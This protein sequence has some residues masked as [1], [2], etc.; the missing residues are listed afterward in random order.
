MKWSVNGKPTNLENKG[1]F[2]GDTLGQMNLKSQV[3]L[4]NSS[5]WF[6]R[7]SLLDQEKA[8]YKWEVYRRIDWENQFQYCQML[9]RKLYLLWQL[10]FLKINKS[11]KKLKLKPT[12]TLYK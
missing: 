2:M 10:R 5:R 6:S 11:E 3:L 9:F 1:I 8:V 4:Y 7:E 12:E